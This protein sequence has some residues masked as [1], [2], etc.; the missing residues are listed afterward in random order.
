MGELVDYSNRMVQLED[1]EDC[2]SDDS[3]DVED[4]LVNWH[5][6]GGDLG[7]EVEERGYASDPCPSRSFTPK[8]SV[9]LTSNL[10]QNTKGRLYNA[11]RGIINDCFFE[12]ANGI[13]CDFYCRYF[14]TN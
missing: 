11:V 6:L 9:I 7:N 10:F 1:E 8:A 12:N 14:E 2:I 4:E 3:V 13:Y 5:V